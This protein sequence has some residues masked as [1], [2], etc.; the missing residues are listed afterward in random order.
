MSLKEV[1]ECASCILLKNV[2]RDQTL[3]WAERKGRALMRHLCRPE[4]GVGVLHCDHTTEEPASVFPVPHL[5]GGSGGCCSQEGLL[6]LG[7]RMLPLTASTHLGFLE[8]NFNV[9]I[10][11]SDAQDCS[12]MHS[13]SLAKLGLSCVN[14]NPNVSLSVLC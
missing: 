14:L 1:K 6:L 5:Q 7:F 4:T 13:N 9:R 2:F 12:L 11:C 10:V 3:R 8:N